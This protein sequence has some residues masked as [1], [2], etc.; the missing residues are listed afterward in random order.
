MEKE[1][2]NL[3]QDV[4]LVC[5]DDVDICR[6][7]NIQLTKEN[8]KVLVVHSG[9]EALELVKNHKISL[10]LL[11]VMMPG[12]DGIV[13]LQKIRE[14]SNLP[15]IL[16]TARSE[17]HDQVIG[18]QV[19]ADAYIT[20]PFN[21][22]VI[23]ANIKAQLRRYHLLG[24]FEEESNTF[25]SGDLVID[26][27]S[28]RCYVGGEEVPLTQIEFKILRYLLK[29]KGKVIPAKEIYEKIWQQPCYGSEGAV[30]VHIRHI[31][32][33]IEAD[34]SRPVYLKVVWGRG[35]QIIDLGD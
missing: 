4:I 2:L 34:A 22:K 19:G 3:D 9:A 29:N 32:Q 17:A 15:V 21:P 11:D 26:D 31:R 18:L 30:T 13:T 12:M 28:N 6:V 8:Y 25:R 16:L 7:L 10:V 27:E 24:A 1:K 14:F 5:D 35:Y 33:K 20:K 23:S